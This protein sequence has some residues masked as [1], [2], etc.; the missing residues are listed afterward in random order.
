MNAE[1]AVDCPWCGSG[2]VERLSRFGTEISKEG[3]FCNDCRSPFERMKYDGE[4]PDTG[5]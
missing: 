2:D 5:R 3:Y 4:R 1:P